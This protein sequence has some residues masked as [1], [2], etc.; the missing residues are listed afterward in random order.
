MDLRSV[1]LNLLVTFEALVEERSVSGAARRLGLTQ[2]ATSHALG[3]LR[4]LFGDEVLVRTA[5]GMTPTPR[6]AAISGTLA[7]SLSDI[8]QALDQEQRFDPATSSRRF[9]L[10]VSDYVAPFLVPTLCR[11]LREQAPGV[12]LDLHHFDDDTRM[13]RSQT[14][15]A[16]A[17]DGGVEEDGVE[18]LR[19]LDDEFVVL[20]SADHPAAG[21]PLTLE[22]YLDLVHVKVSPAALGT[23]VIDDA[24]EARGLRRQIAV[25]VPSW[26]EMRGVVA[27]TDLVVAMPSRWATVPAFSGGCVW[28]PLPLDSATFSVDLRWRRRDRHDLGGRWL[29]D[30]VARSVT[31]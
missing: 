22:G 4:K 9:P 26:F 30:L 31:P 23:N 25:T 2:S 27:H 24:L 8:E 29:R 17:T 16:V 20:M 21:R 11:R 6:A 14:H 28:S 18:R 7:R 5:G 3:R 10:H 12:S 19:L 15:V 1:D 13:G